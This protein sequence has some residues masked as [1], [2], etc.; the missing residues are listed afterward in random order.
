MK[1]EPLNIV[2]IY[3]SDSYVGFLVEPGVNP[4]YWFY[5]V[6]AESGEALKVLDLSQFNTRAENVVPEIV[7][8]DSYLVCSSSMNDFIRTRASVSVFKIS[9]LLE[10]NED[11]PEPQ[12][13]TVPK[14][15]SGSV[16]Q[17]KASADGR[18]IAALI[19]DATFST[20]EVSLLLW[21]ME[22]LHNP[23]PKVKRIVQPPLTSRRGTF[24]AGLWSVEEVDREIEMSY[25]E[26]HL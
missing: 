12:E 23:Q 26:V 2:K 22:A 10:E 25:T 11:M 3:T 5:L 24:T 1:T 8:T 19:I 4:F 21:D 20:K 18:Y 14:T 17:L 15:V 6:D 9:D 13:L 7:L 16:H